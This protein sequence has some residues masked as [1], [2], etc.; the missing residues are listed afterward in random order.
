MLS[1]QTANDSSHWP[2]RQFMAGYTIVEQLWGEGE[3]GRADA[4]LALQERLVSSLEETG[5]TLPP[6]EKERL[7]RLSGESGEHQK[8]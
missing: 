7:A 8:V 4:L 2:T 5:V 1:N 3:D 6:R